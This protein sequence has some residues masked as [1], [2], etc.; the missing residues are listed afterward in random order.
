MLR[1]L[2]KRPTMS[3][4][5]V[6]GRSAEI[7]FG[8]FWGP[9]GAVVALKSDGPVEVLGAGGWIPGTGTG[10]GRL[11]QTPEG[12][13]TAFSACVWAYRC[14]TLRAQKVAELLS[15]MEVVD[16]A[17]KQVVEDHPL[18]QAFDLAY[19]YFDQDVFLEMGFNET[20]FGEVFVEKVISV[21]DLLPDVHL[22]LTVRVLSSL[23]T[24]PQILSGEIQSYVYTGEDR[25][26]TLPPDKV[27][28]LR[29]YNPW[30]PNHGQSRFAAAMEEINVD[31][32]V[33]RFDRSY[34]ANG[35]R[36]GL[37]VSPKDGTFSKTDY[38][39]IKKW[40]QE[41]LVGV[42]NAFRLLPLTRPMDITTAPPIDLEDLTYLTDDMMERIASSIGVPIGLV[43]YSEQAYQ[44]SDQQLENFY[45]NEIAPTARTF[46]R[47]LNAR[48]KPFFDPRNQVKLDVEKAIKDLL[49]VYEDQ[50]LQERISRS[51]W[52]SGTVSLN[53]RLDSLGLPNVVGGD[54]RLFPTGYVA[55][56][57]T[58][59]ARL[60]E[61][62]VAEAPNAFPP[63]EALPPLAPQQILPAAPALT[64]ALTA[65][66]VAQTPSMRASF[67]VSDGT[68]VA[69]LEDVE[70]LMTLQ[71]I[72]QRD[73]PADAPIRWTPREKLH[74]TLVHMPIVDEPIFRTIFETVSPLWT[75]REILQGTRATTLPGGNSSAIPIVAL[76]DIS[77]ELREL[78]AKLYREFT[79]AGVAVSVYSEPS[80]WKAHITLGY[81]DADY[82]NTL[83][84]RAFELPADF[85]VTAASLSFTRG[86]YE[87]IHT[88]VAPAD[89][90]AAPE[91]EV[92][93]AQ[94]V[95]MWRRVTLR[96]GLDRAMTFEGKIL[97]FAV[98]HVLREGLADLKALQLDDLQTDV[99]HFRDVT[100]ALFDIV[101]TYLTDAQD[102]PYEDWSEVAKAI[103]T[104]R[105]EF[106]GAFD[107]TLGEARL[108]N[109]DRRR[110]ASIVRSL[111]RRWGTQAFRDGLV[112]GGYDPGDDPL[113]AEDQADVERFL[114]V[115]S[116][117]VT[118]F[119]DVLFGGG[120]SDGVATYKAGMW[121]HKSIMPLYQMGRLSAD[122][123]QLVEWLI[124]RTEEHCD[125]CLAANGQRHRWREWLR[126]G[127]RPQGDLLMCKGFNCDCKFVPA[128]GRAV[129]R[130]V[131]IPIESI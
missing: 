63:A 2:L 83:P 100:G 45:K 102:W 6:A 119:G 37:I 105:L 73:L 33:I 127:L 110:W 31:C 113:E 60:P 28:Y 118:Q 41:N 38:D 81:V 94:E 61:L 88:E 50:D 122:K 23:S 77:P 85:A 90:A 13:A 27:G 12:Y 123:N 22:P 4:R 18:L 107:E 14:A 89:D 35:A 91:P 32:K 48:V 104:T 43:N 67:G 95:R 99:E 54:V 126:R 120:I 84:E 131:D 86:D 52:E 97:P 125:T 24:E 124:G 68:V 109:M 114:I 74:M 128:T 5:N 56:R 92:T 3:R 87:R 80:A 58:D 76:V 79:G 42:E 55:V 26:A 93:A 71:Q 11:T 59:L 66:T 121:F 39:Q 34:F 98:Q 21:S 25:I 96:K 1:G 129:G 57:E 30:D 19:E 116:E 103:Q 51:Q 46:T 106:E 117:Y 20:I 108:G 62:L 15:H 10:T 101:Y 115:Q 36:P 40:M 16:R 7:P 70:G 112:D 47:F 69:Y 82:F 65:P 17:T 8:F 44:L 29:T 72:M 9:D 53:Q 75:H 111:I 64:R 130:F 78:Q 49:Q